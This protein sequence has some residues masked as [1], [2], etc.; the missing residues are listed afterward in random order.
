MLTTYRRHRKNCE[1]RSEGRKFRRCRCPIWADGF[2]AGQ[3][4]RKSL[5]TVNWQMAQDTVRVWEAKGNLYSDEKDLGLTV[6]AACE[7]FINDGDA[8]GLREPTLYKYRLL[9][10]QLGE[11]SNSKGLRFLQEF[12]VDL[13]RAFRE[14]WPNRNISGRKKL[15]ALRTF[16][17]FCHESAWIATNPAAKLKPPRST[18]AP[19]MP[20]TREEHQ[21]NVA[22]CDRYP[23]K[24][25]SIRLRALILLLRYSGLRIRDAVTL[26][27][28]RVA[29]GNLF[30]YTAKTGTPV[31]CPLPP[32]VLR[33]LESIP[34]TGPYYFWTGDSKPKSAVGN[35]QRALKRLFS[36]AGV[37]LGHAH[38]YRDTFACELLLA[39]VPLERVSI[40][41]GHHSIRVTEKH[42]A[43]WVRSRQEQLEA[44]V[45][46][47]WTEEGDEMKGTL[48]VH[49]T[50]HV[51]N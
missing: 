28:D 16:F 17:R 44:D 37:P 15:E 12:N 14:S 10:R 22:A 8:R 32:F 25:N 13:L 27:R 46:R 4:I 30:L 45:R 19:T 7:R 31:W 29:G 26:S 3:E 41:L 49:R 5:N 35:W 6:K 33:A 38:R 40:L 42:Y 2:L 36:F 11:F 50:K 9:F 51:V 23:D 21:R 20:F 34:A 18:V 47:T 39:G 48:E 1:H 43:P 24:L